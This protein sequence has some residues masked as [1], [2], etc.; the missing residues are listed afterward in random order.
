MESKRK[1]CFRGTWDNDKM[2][3]I[4]VKVTKL[5]VEISVGNFLNRQESISF[6]AVGTDVVGVWVDSL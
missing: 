5:R 6:W 4:V 1:A 2:W 3:A